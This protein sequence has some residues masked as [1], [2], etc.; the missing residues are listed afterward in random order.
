MVNKD[1]QNR[2]VNCSLESRRLALTFYKLQFNLVK[3]LI[4]LPTEF[5]LRPYTIIVYGRSRN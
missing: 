2:V 4:L 1:F 3:Y 5:L